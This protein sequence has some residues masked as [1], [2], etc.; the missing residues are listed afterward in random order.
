MTDHTAPGK[1][2]E[3]ELEKQ[4]VTGMEMKGGGD[5]G[6]DDNGCNGADEEIVQLI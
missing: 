2:W 5:D 4:S 3:N 6:G 1:S